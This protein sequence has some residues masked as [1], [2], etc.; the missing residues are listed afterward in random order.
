M[1]NE[2]GFGTG[3]FP[4]EYVVIPQ[5]TP[6]KSLLQKERPLQ[7]R[8][9]MQTDC[10][11]LFGWMKTTKRQRYILKQ[12]KTHIEFYIKIIHKLNR[13]LCHEHNSKSYRM[14]FGSCG[15]FFFD[16]IQSKRQKS[17]KKHH[18]ILKYT[19]FKQFAQ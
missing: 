10:L 14:T 15:T 5:M 3:A 19:T 16:K 12:M 18:K 7:H 2:S 6:S 4:Y 8:Q 1:Y 9:T 17:T 13:R 11:Q